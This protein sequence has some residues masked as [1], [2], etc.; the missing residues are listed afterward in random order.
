MCMFCAAIPM[1]SSIGSVATAKQKRW[2]RLTQSITPLHL[3]I[4]QRCLLSVPTV[5]VTTALVVLLLLS[6]AYYHSRIQPV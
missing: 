4:R 5:S 1:V 3:S 6:S 2:K